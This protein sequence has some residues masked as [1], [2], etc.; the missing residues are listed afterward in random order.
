MYFAKRGNSEVNV[1]SIREAL[2]DLNLRQYYEDRYR[3]AA[4][5][6]LPKFTP[7]EEKTVLENWEIMTAKRK[8]RAVLYT[9][10]DL[11]FA[12]RG[13]PFHYQAYGLPH[14]PDGKKKGT[15]VTLMKTA[16]RETNN[17]SYLHVAEELCKSYWGW[18]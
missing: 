7:E 6:Q 5:Y 11:Y 16:L 1:S 18:R 12:V 3:I 14:E 2:L 9:E 13:I 4:H 10:L 8:T 17:H 15:S